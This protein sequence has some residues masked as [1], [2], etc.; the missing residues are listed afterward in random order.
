MRDEAV[1]LSTATSGGK[2]KEEVTMKPGNKEVDAYLVLQ[3]EAFRRAL[4]T[5]REAIQAVAPDAEEAFVYGVPGF[6]LEG[7]PL[8]CYAGFK[9]HCGFYPMS[10]AVISLY[11]SEL[12]EY[13]V[14]KGTIRFQPGNM[15]PV[16][17]IKKLVKARM[18]EI[19]KGG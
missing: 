16:R 17:L 5:L 2:S 8:A 18:M 3:P 10:P 14:S 12:K 7:K 6:R 4:Q 19:R 9:S 15:L 13:K 1:G 11:A